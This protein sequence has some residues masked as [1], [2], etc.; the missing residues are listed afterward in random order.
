[1]TEPMKLLFKY[2]LDVA[3]FVRLLILSYGN[4]TAITITKPETLEDFYVVDVT[5][6]SD[7]GSQQT[8]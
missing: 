4:W 7:T 1:M 3:P 8:G 2:R 6:N 5:A